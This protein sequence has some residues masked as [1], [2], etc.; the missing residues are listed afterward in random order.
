MKVGDIVELN[1]KKVTVL[2]DLGHGNF[3]F[4]PVK[5]TKVETK[6][7]KEEPKETKVET[8][9]EPKETKSKAKGKK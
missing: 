3:S 4:G 1:G 6:E 2:A 8:K 9:E 5:E 7:V